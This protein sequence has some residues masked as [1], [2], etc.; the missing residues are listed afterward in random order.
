MKRCS[1]TAS[2]EGKDARGCGEDDVEEKR[3]RKGK[4]LG[5]KVR[6][7]GRRRKSIWRYIQRMSCH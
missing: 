5:R 1:R 3:R 6:R 2:V 7:I 4:R